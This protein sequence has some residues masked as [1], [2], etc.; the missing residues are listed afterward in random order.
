MM[1][2][3]LEGILLELSKMDYERI[4][5]HDIDLEY[6]QWKN[7]LDIY[8]NRLWEII[9]NNRYSMI[10]KIDLILRTIESWEVY[11]HLLIKRC[12]RIG[13]NG[14]CFKKLKTIRSVVRVLGE[15]MIDNL[16]EDKYENKYRR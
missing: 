8:T 4:S 3:Q 5:K 13:N 14:Y 16:Y 2:Y 11:M 12:Y 10:T 6:I 9:D 7:N 15:D 1:E